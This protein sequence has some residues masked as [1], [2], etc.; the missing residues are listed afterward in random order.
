MYVMHANSSYLAL[1]A[2]CSTQIGV[3]LPY[4]WMEGDER[5][6]EERGEEDLLSSPCISFRPKHTIK[7]YKQ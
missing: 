7:F 5:R 1:R 3:V 2:Q 4:V 6:V